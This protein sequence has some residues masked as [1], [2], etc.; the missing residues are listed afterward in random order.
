MLFAEEIFTIHGFP[1]TN[2]ML[3][4]WAAVLVIVIFAWIVRKKINTIPN[5]IQQ[6]FELVL[7]GG[8]SLCD[9]VTG[10]RELSERIFPVSISVFFFILIN[11]WL[12]LLPFGAFGIM[13]D[14]VFIPFLRSGTADLNTTLAL[15]IFT[16]IGA[17]VFGI[18][19]VGAW[20]VFN[21]YINLRALKKMAKNARHE[22]TELIVQPIHF[23]VGIVEI[24][25]EIAKIASLSFR[26]FGNV[27][28]GEVLLAAMTALAA[29][30]VPTPFMFLE[31]LVGL[32]QAVIFAMLVTVYFSI[33]AHDHNDDT[34]HEQH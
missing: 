3:S 33:A 34:A 30:I 10:D 27:F 16:V 15:G 32:I 25:G 1:I 11:N 14:G 4:S 23:F 13:R 28:A 24:V 22:P 31:I 29:Y 20:S 9:Q 19:S 2:A 5:R 6:A 18:L 7:E 21:K 17:N 26:L 8:L 12:G